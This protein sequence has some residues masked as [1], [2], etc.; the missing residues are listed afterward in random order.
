MEIRK[1]IEVS[2]QGLLFLAYINKGRIGA[3][4]KHIA[5]ALS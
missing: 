1:G 4:H 3:R 2:Y 5:R